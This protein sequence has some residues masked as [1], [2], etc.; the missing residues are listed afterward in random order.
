MQS[1]TVRAAARPPGAPLRERPGG[2][3]TVTDKGLDKGQASR[4]AVTA[5]PLGALTK[6]VDALEAYVAALVDAAPPLT[7]DQ[8]ARLRLRLSRD[9]TASPT[10]G[11]AGGAAEWS[12]LLR[13]SGS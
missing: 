9:S 7:A 4:C 5:P 13:L 10:L 12:T 6:G 1:V 11:A 3:D 8:V 2:V